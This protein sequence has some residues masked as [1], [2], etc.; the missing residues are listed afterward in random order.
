MRLALASLAVL[1]MPVHAKPSIFA[2]AYAFAVGPSAYCG[3]PV[4]MG[5]AGQYVLDHSLDAAEIGAL[6]WAEQQ[7]AA[8]MQGAAKA[9]YCVRVEKAARAIGVLP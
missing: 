2:E 6:V 4:D 7:K 3:L 1:A 8:T 9:E 5:K